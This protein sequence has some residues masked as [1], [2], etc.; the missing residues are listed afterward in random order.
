MIRITNLRKRSGGREALSRINVEIADGEAVAILGPSGC[1]KTTLLRCLNGL[2]PFDEGKIEIAG[3]EL[4]PNGHGAASRTPVELRRN[5]GLV[6]QDLHLFA[7]LTVLENIALAP[8]VTGQS[9]A[10]EAGRDALELLDRVGLKDRAGAFPHELSG[11]QKQRVAIARALA[12]RPKVLLLDEPTSAL[13]RATAAS[14]A[15]AIVDLTRGRVTLVVVT[16]HPE[17]ATRMADRILE[18]DAGVLTEKPV[19]G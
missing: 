13:D 4:G 3:F 1:G 9:T 17:L 15:D 7:H 14:A 10:E 16:H 6:F 19:P 12:P 18:L 8:R 11:G 5:V 2:E